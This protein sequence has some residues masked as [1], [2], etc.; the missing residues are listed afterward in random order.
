M[1]KKKRFTWATTASSRSCTPRAI[2]TWVF[3]IIVIFI[4]IFMILMLISMMIFMMTIKIDTLIFM[5][6]VTDVLFLSVIWDK[7]ICGLW[8]RRCAFP[9]A[10]P[11]RIR[12][13]SPWAKSAWKRT[14]RHKL[15]RPFRCSNDLV[16]QPCHRRR[17]C[18]WLQ[19]T[20]YE[21]G[22]RSPPQCSGD[23]FEVQSICRT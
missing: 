15:P 23:Q 1:M 13:S 5:I 12:S 7:E 4:M 10:Y 18:P 16:G 14:H 8:L 21:L 11:T 2:A 20:V 19:S 6:M 22:P 9:S 3:L 17:R